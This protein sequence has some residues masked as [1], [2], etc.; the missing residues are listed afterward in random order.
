MML[1]PAEESGLETMV[2]TTLHHGFGTETGLA[3]GEFYFYEDTFV[4][5][6]ILVPEL[7]DAEADTVDVIAEPPMPPGP[8]IPPMP[9]E[10][11]L[12]T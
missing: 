8:P 7:T 11:A 5:R 9:P 3:E 10:P 4:A 6:M 2:L 12:V 1:V